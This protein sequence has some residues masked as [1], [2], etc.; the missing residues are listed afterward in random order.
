MIETTLPLPGLSSVGSKTVV[1]RFDGGE[2]S[3]D[4]G[5][6]AVREIESRLGVAARLAACLDDPRAPDRV[7]RTHPV[8]D[9][10]ADRIVQRAARW[11]WMSSLRLSTPSSVRAWNHCSPGPN[12]A[13]QPSSGSSSMAMSISHSTSSPRISATRSMVTRLRVL[14]MVPQI[15][16]V[17]S[18]SRFHSQGSSS[19]SLVCGRSLMRARTSASHAWGSMSFIFAV[20]IRLYM[21][22]ARC[23]PRSD[24]QNSH[25]RL[26][27][28]MPRN[29]RSAA[30]LVRQTRPSCRKRVK[31]SQR[32]SM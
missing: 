3:S 21:A 6:L 5:V 7:V 10:G 14:A 25:A 1:A 15:A 29:A 26:P 16:V 23:P 20:T 28:A 31:P 9:A 24:P 13:R 4:A 17:A 22:A 11:I 32:V 27:S 8:S 19:C 30:L 18:C 2:L 12:T